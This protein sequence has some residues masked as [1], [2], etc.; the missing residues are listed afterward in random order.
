M[1]VT[2]QILLKEV[3]IQLSTVNK[4]SGILPALKPLVIWRIEPVNVSKKLDG[5]WKE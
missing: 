1:S 5:F 3:G 4:R 2:S